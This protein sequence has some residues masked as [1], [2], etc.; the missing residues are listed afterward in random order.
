MKRSLVLTAATALL[1]VATTAQAQRGGSDQ[2]DRKD[3]KD[4]D[5]HAQDQR[6]QDKHGQVSPQE[7]KR[8]VDEDR[9]RQ[10]EYSQRLNEQVRAAQARSLELQNQRRTAQLEEH[11][12]YLETLERQRQEQQR[13]LAAR[14]YDRDPYYTTAPTYRYRIS[15]TT[16][17]TNQYGADLL[18]R[19]VNQGYQQGYRTGLADR[20][21]RSPAN[22]Q[23]AFAYQNANDGYTGNYVAESDYNYYFRQGFQRGYDD[24]YGN[25]S[26]YGTVSNGNPSM[27]SNILSGILGLTTI[28]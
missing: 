10:A 13:A 25:R 22:Y 8:R 9:Q 23:R 12:R 5:Q 21:D 4:Q 27:L 7:Q 15:G 26:Q 20:R 17:E 3:K 2:R 19:A 28:R 16:R 6:G 1:F 18:R 14:S 11:Q 24:A